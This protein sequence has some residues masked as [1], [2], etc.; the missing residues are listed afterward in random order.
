MTGRI[1]LLEGYMDGAL[2]AKDSNTKFSSGWW[3][4]ATVVA[5]AMII[6]GFVLVF[7]IAPG[8]SIAQTQSTATSRTGNSP[9]GGNLVVIGTDVRD[10][11]IR[12][13]DELVVLITLQNQGKEPIRMPSGALL[14][15]NERW[16]QGS[17]W[18][19][20]LGEF[21]LARTGV[22]GKEEFTLQP[23]ESVALTA[24]S[25]RLG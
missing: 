16:I 20:G 1:R 19:S 8:S 5:A 14:L 12:F 25:V 10:K 9:T 17:G 13:G 7:V 4:P 3:V 18:G 24:S 15:K 21:P 11:T 6:F 23:G 2:K 22:Y